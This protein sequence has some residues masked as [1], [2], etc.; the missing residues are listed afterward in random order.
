MLGNEWRCYINE[1]RSAE[2]DNNKEV[3]KVTV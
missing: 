3:N 2:K 1:Y